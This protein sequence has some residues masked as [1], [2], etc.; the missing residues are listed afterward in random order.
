M[1]SIQTQLPDLSPDL[2]RSLRERLAQELQNRI[3]QNRLADYKPY[4]KQK[5]FHALIK[6]ERLL[7]AGNQLGKTVAGAAEASIH[8]TGKYPEWWTGRRFDAPTVNWAAGVTGLSTR[9]N[10]QRLLVGRPGRHGTGYLPKSDLIAVVPARGIADL[11]DHVRVRHVAGGESLIYLK[12][13]EQGREKWQGETLTGFVW[14]DEE[15]PLDIYS[16][17]LTRTQATNAIAWVTFTPLLGMSDVVARFL[18]E[19]NPDRATVTMT[20]DDAEHYTPEERKRIIDGYPIHE[21]EARARGIPIMGS[22]RVFP[23]AEESVVCQPFPIP[24]WWPRVGGV[25]FGWDHPFAAVNIAWDRDTDTTYVTATYRQREA[26]P[27]I[28]TAALKPWLKE[29]PNL[30]FAWPHDGLQHDKQ[31]GKTLADAYRAEGLNLH[32]THA[33]HAGGDGKG[34]GLEAGI[35]AMLERMQQGRLKVFSNLGDWFEEFR[36]YH[37]KD[38]LIVKERDD[39]MSAT[40]I[41]LMMLR[42]ARGAKDP[43][44]MDRYRRNEKRKSNES[45]L[46]A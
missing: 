10:V 31:S 19:P 20:I 38:G 8:A 45:W 36:L 14:F 34:F 9:D 2:M 13:Y 17:G 35:M 29:S 18:M 16:E 12:S 40:R 37:R 22:G 7:M 3:D 24:E 30:M 43:P 41:A 25:D 6:R 26:T 28:H 1:D 27:L 44:V 33:T 11:A 46:T 42:I 15:P 39:L 23:V 5:E 32:F 21:R 4:S